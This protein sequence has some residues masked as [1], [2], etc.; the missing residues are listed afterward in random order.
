VKP[1]KSFYGH[2]N[3]IAHKKI[4]AKTQAQKS[5]VDQI[6][7]GYE[8]L[9]G[10]LSWSHHEPG[11]LTK[12]VS[13]LNAYT[14]FIKRLE[15]SD[16]FF[17]WRGD[18]ASSLLPE[19]L[20]RVIAQRMT[21]SQIQPLYSTR[22]SVVDITLNGYREGGWTI[23]KKNQD[24]CIGLRTDVI[25]LGQKDLSFVVPLIAIEAKT[26]IDINKLNGLDFS[27]ERLKRTFPASRYFLVTETLDFAVDQNYA[28]SI[29]EIYVLRKQ[30]RSDARRSRREYCPDVFEEFAEDV[31]RI[32]SKADTSRTHVYDRLEAGRLINV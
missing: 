18:F 20:F 6:I 27:A 7:R 19:F 25:N 9:I 10:A 23:R 24:L 22:D 8:D 5:S 2:A 1:D 11:W 15:A 14:E 17:N 12:A 28:G 31:V 3:N 30:K 29:D 32:V 4:I 26:N 21:Y 16:S 13:G